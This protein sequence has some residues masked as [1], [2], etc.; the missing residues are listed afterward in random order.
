MQKINR[1][2]FLKGT[3]ALTLSGF[4]AVTFLAGCGKKKEEPGEAKE[5]SGPCSDLSG[6]S[7]A[8][9]ETRELYRYVADSPHEDKKCHL[10]NYFIP[11]ENNA[12]CGTCQVVKGPINPGG[13]CTSWV[14]K[15]T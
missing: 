4:G 12:P 11:P 15:M 5:A 7:A 3:A 6:L 14:K 2:N 1:K 10:C 13:Y 8:D 9:K